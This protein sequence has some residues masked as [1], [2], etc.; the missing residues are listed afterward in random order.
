MFSDRSNDIFNGKIRARNRISFDPHA[1][2]S[3]RNISNLFIP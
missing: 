2:P 1:R 3:L